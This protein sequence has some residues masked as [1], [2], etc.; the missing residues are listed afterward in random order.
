MGRNDVMKDVGHRIR[1]VRMSRT[2]PR[3]TQEGLSKRA[4][5]SVSFLSMIERGERAPHIETLF[6]IAE[7]LEVGLEA[8]FSSD[9]SL[10]EPIFRPVLDACRKHK[11]GKRDVQRLVSMMQILFAR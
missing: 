10:V 8:L 1:S 6:R 2:G 11:L 4:R 7:G 3:L 9:T 5:I